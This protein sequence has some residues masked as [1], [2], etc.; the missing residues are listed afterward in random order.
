MEYVPIWARDI[1]REGKS[2]GKSEEKQE[3]AKRM[4]NKGFRIKT[5]SECL[6]ISVEEVKKLTEKLIN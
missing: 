4:L 5:I 3:V 2:E 1:R 6:D